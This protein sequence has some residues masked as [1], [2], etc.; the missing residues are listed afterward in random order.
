VVTVGKLLKLEKVI[1]L[2]EGL[3]TVPYVVPPETALV[4]VTFASP[5]YVPA[6]SA[7]DILLAVV[8]PWFTLRAKQL[9]GTAALPG[10]NAVPGVLL[11]G[12]CVPVQSLTVS[13]VGGIGWG[14]RAICPALHRPVTPA[15]TVRVPLALLAALMP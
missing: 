7:R 2:P 8:E 10:L 3:L 11:L 1:A 15:V 14:V 6:D 13:A 12:F 4:R 5:V 9:T